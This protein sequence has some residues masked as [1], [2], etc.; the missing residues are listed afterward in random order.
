MVMFLEILNFMIERF[1]VLND[2]V[3]CGTDFTLSL[4]KWLHYLKTPSK[5]PSSKHISQ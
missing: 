3:Y 2:F 1:R 5:K 4:A